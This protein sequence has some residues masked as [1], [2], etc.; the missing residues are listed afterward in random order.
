MPEWI[1][2]VLS[3]IGGVALSWVVLRVRFERFEA[4]DTR[5]EQD[6]TAWRSEVDEKL[7]ELNGSLLER[8]KRLESD[9]GTHE[10]GIRGTVHKCANTL[11]VHEGRLLVLEQR[12]QDER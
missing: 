8:V 12:R 4:M 7:H 3:L 1:L 2:P 6:W 11:I 9:I 10:T 5:R